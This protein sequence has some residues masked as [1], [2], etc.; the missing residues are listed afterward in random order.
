MRRTA[1]AA[2]TLVEL[3]V[4]IGIIA[5]LVGILLPIL[6]RARNSAIKTVCLANLKQNHGAMGFYASDHNG[7][8]PL[9]YTNG[10]KQFNYVASRNQLAFNDDTAEDEPK[11]PLWLGQLWLVGLLEEGET[12][13]CPAEQDPVVQQDTA[14]NAWPPGNVE[15]FRT[16]LGYGTR[17]MVDWPEPADGDFNPLTE[18]PDV[19]M[20]RLIDH[21][22]DAILADLLHKPS[23]IAERHG[24]GIQVALGHGAARFVPLAVLEAVEVDGRRWLDVP[25][26]FDPDFNDVFLKPAPASQGVWFAISE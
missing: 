23:Q 6:S 17:P 20:P 18:M 3:L 8:L 11:R 26:S 4:V 9:G 5:V 25:D 13:F 7:R 12:W 2:F 24:D 19:P 16:R 1:P 14:R 22:N 15:S 21:N 10:W